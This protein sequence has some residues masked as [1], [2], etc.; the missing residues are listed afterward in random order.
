MENLKT[1]PATAGEIAIYLPYYPASR[2]QF[3]GP[4][5]GLYKG[6]TLEG[7]RRVEGSSGVP[8]VASWDIK[9]LPSDT[10]VC[11]V[12]FIDGDLFLDYELALA[13][14]E[15]IGFLMEMANNTADVLDFPSQFY[16]KLLGY[17]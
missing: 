13:N 16:R 3:L 4:A 5:L 9:S 10:T 2:R 15:F 17:S 14:T 6:G 12:R 7:Q 11:R 1:R 8:F